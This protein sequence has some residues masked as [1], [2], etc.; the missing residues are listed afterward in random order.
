[1]TL[2]DSPFGDVSNAATV[3]VTKREVSLLM[4]KNEENFFKMGAKLHVST[5]LRWLYLMFCHMACR[6]TL[7][8]PKLEIFG[9]RVF[10]QIRPVCVGDLG[11]RRKIHNFDGLGLKKFLPPSPTAIEIFFFKTIQNYVL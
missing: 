2:R 4:K 6:E 8:G 5:Q 9:S 11:T 10:P 3:S 7:K 1:M